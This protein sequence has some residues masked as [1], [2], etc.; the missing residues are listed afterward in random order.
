MRCHNYVH[1]TTNRI[2][3]ICE[4]TS[5]YTGKLLKRILAPWSTSAILHLMVRFFQN[6]WGRHYLVASAPPQYRYSLPYFL[7]R[8]LLCFCFVP[9]VSNLAYVVAFLTKWNAFSLFVIEGVEPNVQVHD[10]P[11]VNLSIPALPSATKT[12][13]AVLYRIHLSL[14]QTLAR[15]DRNQ[16]MLVWL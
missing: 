1:S 13:V 15:L 2:V 16:Q 3:R 9:S 10:I 11:Q 5:C 14:Y 8:I 6:K 12:Q 7:A 4:I